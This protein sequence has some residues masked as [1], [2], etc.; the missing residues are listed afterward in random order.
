MGGGPLTDPTPATSFFRSEGRLLVA[1]AVLLV[2]LNVPYGNYVLYPFALFGTWVHEL[3][4]ALAALAVGGSVSQIE[5]FS[6]TSGLAWTRP[7]GRLAHAVV[8]SAGYTGTALGGMLL[9]V[10]RRRAL[11]GR[12]G[13]ALLGVA[14]VLTAVVWVRNAFGTPAIL[15]LGAA[16]LAAGWKLPEELSGWLYTFLAAVTSLDAVTSIQ[17][18][19]G[20]T[21][22]VNGAPSS[23]DART[24][25]ELLLIPWFA[26]ASLWMVLAL[27]CAWIGL[28]HAL[29]AT[30]DPAPQETS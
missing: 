27:I 7:G 3:C 19:F 16:L 8:A 28:R 6:D 12:I 21:H 1:V 24:V 25:G 15:V 10:F 2:L 23:T 20:S 9:L 18:L 14:M 26:W 5:I 17:T 4:H 13:L 29:P 22:L 30:S 11:A